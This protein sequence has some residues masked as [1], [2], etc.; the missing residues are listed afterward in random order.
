M[1]LA[2]QYDTVKCQ[3]LTTFGMEIDLFIVTQT[4]SEP[5]ET[6]INLQSIVFDTVSILSKPLPPPKK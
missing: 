1:I 4:P 6:R 5:L 3:T 2:T